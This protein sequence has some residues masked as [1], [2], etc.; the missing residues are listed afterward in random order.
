MSVVSREVRLAAVPRGL[1]V[2]ADLE[3]TEAAPLPAPAPGEVL[4]RNRHF[5]VFGGLRTLLGGG[6]E[7]TP[8]PGLRPGDTLFG[9]AVGEVVAAPDGGPLRPGDLVTHLLGWREYTLVPAAQCA[10]VDPALPDPVAHLTSGSAAYGALTRLAEL[11]EGDVVLV[12]G[13]AG[14]V[15][16]LAGQIAR[17]LGAGRVIGTTGSPGK[18]ER[19]TAELGYDAVL[20]GGSWRDGASAEAA[21]AKELAEA[22]PDGVDVLLDNVGG[23][24][25]TAAVDAARPGARF[26]LVGALSGQFAA[27]TAG[28]TGPATVDAFRLIVKGVSLRGYTG[29]AHPDVEAEWTDRLADWLRAGAIRLPLTRYPGIDQAPRALRELTRGDVFGTVVVDL[30]DPAHD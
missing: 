3:L 15:G 2:P 16:S 10:P 6:V 9:P 29:V 14:G 19:L 20:T 21:F 27:D 22:A 30:P 13:A 11:R 24:Q 8:V 5:Q 18:A 23:H 25:L 1:P 12:T 28:A 7:G 26:A 17:L 4:V